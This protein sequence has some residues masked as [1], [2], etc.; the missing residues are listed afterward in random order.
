[1]ADMCVNS[2]HL[3]IT[4]DCWYNPKDPNDV[5]M[6]LDG[7]EWV[8]YKVHWGIGMLS[9]VFGPLIAFGVLLFIAA[10]I[11]YCCLWVHDHTHMHVELHG[12]L[13]DDATHRAMESVTTGA[14]GLVRGT[15]RE[16]N[17]NK[18]KVH[19]QINKIQRSLNGDTSAKE[20]EQEPPGSPRSSD[21]IGELFEKL[22]LCETGHV[23][24]SVILKLTD[25]VNGMEPPDVAANEKLSV[26]YLMQN[27]KAPLTEALGE[28]SYNKYCKVRITQLFRA[29]FAK[30]S[31]PTGNDVVSASVEVEDGWL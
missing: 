12:K 29:I 19:R 8:R 14:H 13:P 2:F 25:K 5:T 15:S 20:K 4:D 22:L 10:S 27:V 11:L 7:G 30:E 17:S 3:F 31:E 1:M 16:I 6:D 21:D 18:R 28:S 23:A 26:Q 24:E 9:W